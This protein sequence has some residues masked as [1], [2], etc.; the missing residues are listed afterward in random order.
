MNI[1]GVFIWGILALTV[2]SIVHL[3]IAYLIQRD[4]D[5]LTFKTSQLSVLSEEVSNHLLNSLETYEKK[6]VDILNNIEMRLKDLEERS[7]FK[8]S[9]TVS[10]DSLMTKQH[11]G[12]TP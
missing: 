10:S 2:Y 3:V 4:K 6:V 1:Q 9:T 7:S 8:E 12:E 11:K 5:K